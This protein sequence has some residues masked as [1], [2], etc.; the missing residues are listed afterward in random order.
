[1][2][3]VLGCDTRDNRRDAVN[4]N[5]RTQGTGTAPDTITD[6]RRSEGDE[7]SVEL[8]SVRCHPRARLPGR[9][10]QADSV[11]HLAVARSACTDGGRCR[12]EDHWA[13]HEPRKEPRAEWPFPHP[14]VA[15]FG[16]RRR[17]TIAAATEP[18]RFEIR[19]QP[20]LV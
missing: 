15:G 5:Q 12:D 7:Q 1:P 6:E 4:G 18:A 17:I 14:E 3:G 13:Q 16:G 11:A 9:S 2:R 8:E 19:S 20:V 10:E